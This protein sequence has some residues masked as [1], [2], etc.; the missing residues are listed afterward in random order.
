[1][2]LPDWFKLARDVKQ[3]RR[4]EA[5][6]NVR[7][8]GKPMDRSYHIGSRVRYCLLTDTPVRWDR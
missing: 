8:H 4:A 2:S 6:A 1:M 3:D 7:A 5:R